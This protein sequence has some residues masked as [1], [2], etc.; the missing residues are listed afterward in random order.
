MGTYALIVNEDHK[1]ERRNLKIGV[2]K[3]HL[4]VIEEGLTGNEWVITNGL[5]KAMP[6]K[7]VIAEQDQI[8]SAAEKPVRGT[9]K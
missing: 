5:I 1:V 8:H 2:Q 6:G 9:D 7:P 3:G 4:Q